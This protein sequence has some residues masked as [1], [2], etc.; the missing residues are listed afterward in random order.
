MHVVSASVHQPVLGG[1]GD[2]G[3]LDDRQ[4][5]ELGA[6]DDRGSII[7]DA[8]EQSRADHALD[9]SAERIGDARGR[10]GLEMTE[11]GTR[12]QQTPQLRG[13]G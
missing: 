13:G 11:L 12:V 2:A 9:G 1:E 6:R 5:V 10:L 3:P 4:S 8:D 7:S